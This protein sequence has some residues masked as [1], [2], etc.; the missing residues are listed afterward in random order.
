MTSNYFISIPEAKSV[1]ILE[2]VDPVF[3][4][5]SC[6]AENMAKKLHEHRFTVCSNPTGT[7]YNPLSIL[8]L[9]KRLESKTPL[10]N[11]SLFERNGQFRSFHT[12]TALN[13]A[14][15]E[16]YLSG[17]NSALQKAHENLLQTKVVLL[18]FGTSFVWR[19]K[20]TGEV[21]ANCQK[22]PGTLFEKTLLDE[23]AV[24]SAI[25]ECIE[26]VHRMNPQAHIV[27]TV[28]PVRYERKNPFLNS[29]S[30]GRLFSAIHKLLSEKVLYFPA[31]EILHDELRDYRFYA[32]DMMHP[33]SVTQKEIWQRFVRQ[34]CSEDCQMFIKEYAKLSSLLQHR[35]MNCSK[36]SLE[37]YCQRL[38]AQVEVI[39][40]SFS[41]ALQDERQHI[42]TLCKI[43]I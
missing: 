16:E 39:E 15:A 41:L 34:F 32:E 21:V 29:V 25:L 4:L 13:R 35:V 7:L 19:L 17:V 11:S 8:S 18:T 26:I 42:A 1:G 9:L 14:A 5:G 24:T 36:D 12:H 3:L 38:Y 40:R 31:F 6:F 22:E 10:T 23:A 2:P 28:S 27:L 33:S 30:K 20:E 43:C 37:S